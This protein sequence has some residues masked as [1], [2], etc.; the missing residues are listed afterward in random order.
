[1][2]TTLFISLLVIGCGKKKVDVKLVP[3]LTQY[4]DPLYS[5]EVS[6]PK[7]WSKNNEIGTVRYY[8]E[9]SS[10]NRFA[11][12]LSGAGQGGV[13]IKLS[14]YKSGETLE[15]IAKDY[16]D[17]ARAELRKID[18]EEKV[19][20]DNQDGIK[21]SL[22]SNYG[23]E[24]VQ[25]SY[26]IFVVTDSLVTYI[27]CAAFNTDWD[28]YGQIFDAVVKSVKIGKMP[29]AGAVS[30]IIEKPSDKFDNYSTSFFTISYPDNFNFNSPPKGKNEF[31]V[32][33]KGQ[34][35]DCTVRFDV[36]PAKGLTVEKVVNQNKAAYKAAS[37]TPVTID[38]VS[39]QYMNYTQQKNV[40]SRAY[41]VV[42]ND[43]VIRITLNW[44]TPENDTYKPIFER[45][46]GSMKL[47]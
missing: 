45:V 23:K 10:M 27:D 8:P 39:A 44:Y 33:L 20:V 34:R 26:R 16:K 42:K 30:N 31:S 3:E 18:L 4:K 22:T 36:F 24:N 5:F 19:K 40:T 9:Q 25:K 41:F 15:K 12:P 11:D 14:C 2:L 17:T 7:D 37:S 21:I 29:T 38:G 32:E 6:Y 43:K 13:Q 1:M 28:A 46:I 47:K 35:L